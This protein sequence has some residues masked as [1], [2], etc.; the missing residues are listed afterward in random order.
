MSVIE[1]ASFGV[2]STLKT[3]IGRANF[4]VV[5]RLS[6]TNCV[7]M[8]SPVAPLSNKVVRPCSTPVSVVWMSTFSFSEVGEGVDATMYFFGSRLS[9]FRG[10][11]CLGRG[12]TS[13]FEMFASLWGRVSVSSFPTESTDKHAKRFELGSEG[14]LFTRCSTQN[15]LL[16]PKHLRPSFHVLRLCPYPP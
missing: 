10:F 13:K 14:V 1:P 7:S 4:R 11:G 3:G 5:S 6:C 15:P 16:W 9:H 12:G 2:P 8:N